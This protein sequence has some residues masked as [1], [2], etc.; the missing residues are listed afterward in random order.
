MEVAPSNPERE[1]LLSA[2]RRRIERWYPKVRPL[3]PWISLAMGVAGALLLER[4]P[5]KAPIAAAGAV[6]GLVLLLGFVAASSLSRARDGQA[7]WVE[8]AKLVALVGSQSML[9][10]GLFFSVPFY[11]QAM[12]WEPGHVIFVGV[13]GALALVSLWDPLYFWVAERP[14]LGPLVQSLAA[15]ATANAV[16][17]VLGI[18]N[19][20]SLAVS[21]GLVLLGIP[22][23][24]IVTR[25]LDWPHVLAAVLLPVALRFGADR[26]VPAAPLRLGA[27]AFGTS[28]DAPW[29]AD[30]LGKS[31]PVPEQLVCATAIIAPRG[32]RD[33]LVHRWSQGG[34]TRDE[35]PLDVRG[36][37]E[38]GYRTFSVKHNIGPGKW[39]CEVRTASGQLL[40]GPS[41]ELRATR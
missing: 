5:D 19:R 3:F 39:R 23:H 8:G 12:V 18:E 1:D 10:L 14:F 41:I 31:A 40:G 36:G 16:L 33:A 22:I 30:E 9:Q 28:V 34:Q 24:G 15:F 17:P 4:T 21:A 2:T 7:Q 20:V 35:I 11:A 25:R 29:V 32:L 37:R 26:L 13:L 38:K 27:T 6:A